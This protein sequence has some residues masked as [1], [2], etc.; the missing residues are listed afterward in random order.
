MEASTQT[1]LN[2]SRQRDRFIA[3]SAGFASG[4]LNAIVARLLMRGIALVEFGEGSFSFGGTAT[5]FLFGALVGPLLGLLYGR[6][7]YRLRTREV[8]KGLLFGLILLVTLQLLGLY[9]APDFRAELM[10]VG[11]LGFAAFAAMNFAFVLTLAFLT[12]WLDRVWPKDPS[13]QTLVT[14]VTVVFGLLALT[15]LGLL[16]YEIGGRL[17]GLVK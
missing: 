14:I 1:Q 9:V 16:A 8:V 7:L 2:R 12:P 11:P 17:L 3:L 6:T 15:G 13:G 5:I 10:D 4:V